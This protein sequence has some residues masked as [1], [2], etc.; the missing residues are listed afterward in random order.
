[1]SHLL[2][3]A[4]R[5]LDALAANPHDVIEGRLNSARYHARIAIPDY[6]DRVARYYAGF[7]DLAALCRRSAVDFDFPSFG[8]VCE[9]DR[10]VE[11]ALH[12]DAQK[13]D[14]GVRDIVRRFGPLIVRNAHV[15]ADTTGLQQRN[16]FSNL[17]F[18]FDRGANQP[19]QYSLFIRDPLDPVQAKPR[20][21]STVFVANI[22][23]HLQQAAE[24]GCRPED[25]K[26]QSRYEIFHRDIADALTNDVVLEH[27]WTEPEGTGE[28][29]LL[30]NRSV[31]HA[32]YYRGSTDKG[33]PIS[34][35]YLH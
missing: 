32:S 25:L 8:F 23:A 12:D 33:Y 28:M 1:M 6:G 14:D 35:R 30:F 7:G 26:R 34:V 20:T 11:L 9:F 13:L 16:I 17:A 18:H 3:I 24:R 4:A 19:E 15:P 22:V 5:A 2:E 31:F 21:S 27:P 29:S 10:P